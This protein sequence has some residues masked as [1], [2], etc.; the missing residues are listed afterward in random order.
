MAIGASEIGVVPCHHK[1]K[2]FMKRALALCQG[3][4]L[5][6]SDTVMLYKTR[7]MFYAIQAAIKPPNA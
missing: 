2:S 3:S 6:L 1:R 5:H 4:F 7:L